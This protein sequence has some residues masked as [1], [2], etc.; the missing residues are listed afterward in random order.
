[1]YSN[2]VKGK[3]VRFWD[4]GKS[5]TQIPQINAEEEMQGWRIPSALICESCV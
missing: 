2:G 3:V 4:G 1:M 5:Q